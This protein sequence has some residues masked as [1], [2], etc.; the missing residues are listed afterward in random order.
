MTYTLDNKDR[1]GFYTVG[2]RKTY[3][4]LE[5]IDH[6]HAT[7]QTMEWHFNRAVY[8]S[9]DWQTE[10]DASLD[11]LYE[12]RA[13]QLREQYDYL[14]LWYSGGADS[15]NILMAF[16][17]AGIYIDEIA[18]YHQLAAHGGDQHS[19]TNREVFETSAPITQRLIAS[20]PI[21]STTRHR[22]VDMTEYQTEMFFDRSNTWDYFYKINSYFSPNCL[23]R[24]RFR[25]KISD[26]KRIID[27]GQ[28]LCFVFGVE[29]PIVTKDSQ[30]YWVHF[31]DGQDHGVTAWAQIQNRPGDFDEFFYW[32][33]DMPQL[34][35]KQAH[36]IRRYMEYVDQDHIDNVHVGRGPWVYDPYGRNI[37]DLDQTKP[38][39]KFKNFGKDYYL[40]ARGVHRLIY[41]DWDPNAVVCGKPHSNMF[42]PRDSWLWHPS[43]PDIGQKYYNRGLVW[44]RQHVKKKRPDLWNEMQFD[45]KIA[46][47]TA[48]MTDFRN[49]YFLGPARD[50]QQ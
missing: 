26:W 28:R 23:S 16:V 13:R 17:R 15:H 6:S 40:S 49:S 9:F 37:L 27:S 45:P 39:I 33:P 32:A 47:Y 46:P 36:V 29:K 43:A 5:A 11:S 19:W 34:P 18:Q 21:Y 42:P 7:G 22:M 44:L 10:P 38:L 12:A 31:R 8:S 2:S 3:S 48:W 25:E 20:N 41:P 30:G 1:Y 14:V 50:S 35:A 4:K 24:Y